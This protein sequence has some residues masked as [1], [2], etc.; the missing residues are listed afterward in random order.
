MTDLAADRVQLLA[1][2]CADN[3][4]AQVLANRYHGG[5]DD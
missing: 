2:R 5:L 1:G 3:P 4:L